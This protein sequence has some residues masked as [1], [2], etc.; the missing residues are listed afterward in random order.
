MNFNKINEQYTQACSS[1]RNL[2]LRHLSLNALGNI[3]LYTVPYVIRK[4]PL[5]HFPEML[6]EADHLEGKKIF[7]K[8]HPQERGLGTAGAKRGRGFCD[9][10]ACPSDR[11]RPSSPK[12][13]GSPTPDRSSFQFIR[14]SEIGTIDKPPQCLNGSRRERICAC[15]K[16]NVEIIWN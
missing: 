16:L 4:F 3:F 11:P 1:D 7:N 14:P 8:S 2:R 5:N 9:S 10:Q 15:A 6:A 13:P 12:K